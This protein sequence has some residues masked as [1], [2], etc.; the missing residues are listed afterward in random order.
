MLNNFCLEDR[1]RL[2]KFFRLVEHK[3]YFDRL[4][5]SEY[6]GFKPRSLREMKQNKVMREISPGKYTFTNEAKQRLS[7]YIDKHHEEFCV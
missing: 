6:T 2:A 1:I 5:Y 4:E 3:N 7:S